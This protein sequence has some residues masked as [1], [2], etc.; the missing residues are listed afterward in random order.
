MRRHRLPERSLSEI[1]EVAPLMA[2]ITDK[3]RRRSTSENIKV[4]N[5]MQKPFQQL[6]HHDFRQEKL[7]KIRHL[8]IKESRTHEEIQTRKT[9]ARGHVAWSCLQLWRGF[10]AA[11]RLTGLSAFKASVLMIPRSANC[12][13]VETVASSPFERKAALNPMLA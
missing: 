6:L 11:S 12:S 4:L 2:I 8:K 10:P 9:L 1:D 7:Q 13:N 5:D 3:S